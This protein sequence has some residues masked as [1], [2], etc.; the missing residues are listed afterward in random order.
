M[1]DSTFSNQTGSNKMK[2][3]VMIGVIW[4]LSL[5]FVLCL[6]GV[7]GM[8]VEQ[9][10]N[11][12]SQANLTSVTVPQGEVSNVKLILQAWQ[13]I[14]DNYVDQPSAKSQTLT[15]GA[16][17]GMTDALGDTGHSRFE[18]PLMVKEEQNYT[19]GTFEGI[20][21]M[22][23]SKNGNTIIVAPIDNSP[24]Q[25]AGIIAGDIIQKVDGKDV[26]GMALTDVVN[27]ILGPAGTKVT[28]TIVRPSTGEVKDYTI[29]RAKIT[30]KNVTWS[31]VPG[32][33]LAHVRVAAFSQNVTRDLQA[34]LSQMDQQ[35]ATGVILD[36]RNDAGGLLD[37]SIGVASQFLSGGNVLLTK[38]VTGKQTA[39]AV[40]PGGQA[41]KIPMVILI[42]QGTASAS[43]IVTGAL[44]D[45]KRGTVIGDKTF[46]TGTV[47]VP[48]PLSDGSSLLLATEEWLT[49]AGRVI[50]HNGLQPDVPVALP[51]GIAPLTP[52]GERGMTADQVKSSQDSQLLKAIELLSQEA[53]KSA[54]PLGSVPLSQ[55]LSPIQAEQVAMPAWTQPFKLQGVSVY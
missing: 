35:H 55:P 13:I 20:G 38:D 42:N 25:Q 6:G 33:T 1:M 16:I 36:L 11:S 47:L 31:M 9:V 49:P 32:T 40:R 34:A 12:R 45:A 27:R 46:G 54:T 14:K 48:F 18:T 30:V 3:R 2:K 24:A 26:T 23:Q 52:E 53:P 21:A 28:V 5:L 4:G 8:V 51:S 15:Y 50:W 7:G 41:T 10:L 44:Q 43:E 37:E 17:T 19:Q 29:T 39:S 22:V